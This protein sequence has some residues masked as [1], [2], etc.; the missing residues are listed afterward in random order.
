M[1]P[2]QG[3]A[4]SCLAGTVKLAFTLPPGGQAR[5]GWCMAWER[6]DG[7]AVGVHV[8]ELLVFQGELVDCGDH[9]RRVIAG[10]AVSPAHHPAGSGQRWARAS[11]AACAVPCSRRIAG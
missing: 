1:A 9:V 8:A 3:Q 2:G 11:G 5:T 4:T 10:S 7:A 6:D